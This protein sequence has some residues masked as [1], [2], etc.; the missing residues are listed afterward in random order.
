M[1]WF[2]KM[3]LTEMLKV[4]IAIR[5]LHPEKDNITSEDIMGVCSFLFFFAF[6]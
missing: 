4:I 5:E 6:I 3:E 2:F 1:T